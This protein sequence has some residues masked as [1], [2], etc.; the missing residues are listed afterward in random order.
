MAGR[1]G[2]CCKPLK[3]E[4]AHRRQGRRRAL[5]EAQEEKGRSKHKYLR[6]KAFRGDGKYFRGYHRYL[7]YR[8]YRGDR[9]YFG[10]DHKYLRY[11]AGDK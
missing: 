6:C 2:S 9:T 3:R 11:W 1:T 7:R 8:Y 5:R 4:S 10:G